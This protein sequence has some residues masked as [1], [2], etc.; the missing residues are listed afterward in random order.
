M[1]VNINSFAFAQG[2]IHLDATISALQS[3]DTS[4]ATMHLQEAQKN[5]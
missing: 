3:G 5:Q 1:T 4:G 2:N